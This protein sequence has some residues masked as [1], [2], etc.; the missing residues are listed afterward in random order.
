MINLMLEDLNVPES[1]RAEV[2]DAA[3]FAQSY[4]TINELK[5]Y[6][7]EF[8]SLLPEHPFES[9]EPSN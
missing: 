8:V 5:A 9:R 7:K 4:L 3:E 1:L 6:I 2:Y